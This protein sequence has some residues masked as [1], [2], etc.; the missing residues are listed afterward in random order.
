MMAGKGEMMMKE[1]EEGM[2]IRF[3]GRRVGWRVRGGLWS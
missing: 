3:M 1:E 2:I